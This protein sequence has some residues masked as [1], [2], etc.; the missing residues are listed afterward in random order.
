MKKE[1]TKKE[2]RELLRWVG[3]LGLANRFF[4]LH[5]WVKRNLDKRGEWIN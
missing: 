2:E 3:L 4:H 1:I 5:G